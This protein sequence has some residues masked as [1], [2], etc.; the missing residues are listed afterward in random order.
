MS[1]FKKIRLLLKSSPKLNKKISN[2]YLYKNKEK[3]IKRDF[4]ANS[5]IF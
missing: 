3:Q 4:N 1:F 5:F 2:Y